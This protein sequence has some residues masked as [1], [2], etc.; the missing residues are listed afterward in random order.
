LR[1]D[2]LR[3][4]PRL[5]TPSTVR[6]V[7]VAHVFP[8]ILFPAIVEQGLGRAAPESVLGLSWEALAAEYVDYYR[9][10]LASP[11]KAR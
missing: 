9:E 1:E 7:R 11:R 8:A 5:R 3:G 4:Q 10:I 2:V 6:E